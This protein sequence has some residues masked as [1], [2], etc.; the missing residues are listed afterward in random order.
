[1]AS[2]GNKCVL[3]LVFKPGACQPQAGA[4]LVSYNSFCPGSQNV[5]A[6]CVC[7]SVPRLLTVNGVIMTPYDWVNKF[8]SF[9]WQL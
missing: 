3:V 4:H 1:M 2:L 6:L 8:Y 5:S 7:V 9:I